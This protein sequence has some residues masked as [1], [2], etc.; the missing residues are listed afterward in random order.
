MLGI[1]M[2]DLGAW[3]GTNRACDTFAGHDS[4][5]D[6]DATLCVLRGPPPGNRNYASRA[7]PSNVTPGRDPQ[8]EGRR[9]AVHTPDSRMTNGSSR[10][11]NPNSSPAFPDQRLSRPEKGKQASSGC[12]CLAENDSA[13]AHQFDAL[14]GGASVG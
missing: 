4:D 3:S 5:D 14:R 2:K 11:G 13:T 8:S 7:A 10:S 6:A 1:Q 12:L 9:T